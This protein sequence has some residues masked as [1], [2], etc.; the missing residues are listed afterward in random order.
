MTPEVG[1]RIHAETTTPTMQRVIVEVT[2]VDSEV[3]S[4]WYVY[5][6][7]QRRTA[8]GRPRQ[9]MYPALYFVPKAP[10]S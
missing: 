1:K 5:G 8:G 10:V 7:R 6:Y 3:E 2:K 9:T 4:G